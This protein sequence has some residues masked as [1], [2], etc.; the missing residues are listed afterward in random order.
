MLALGV[1]FFRVYSVSREFQKNRDILW[2]LTERGSAKPAAIRLIRCYDTSIF[3][4]I[5][6]QN[7]EINLKRKSKRT[8]RI[9][10]ATAELGIALFSRYKKTTVGFRLHQG[11]GQGGSLVFAWLQVGPPSAPGNGYIPLASVTPRPPHTSGAAKSRNGAFSSRG[12]MRPAIVFL[13]AGPIRIPLPKL[14]G[15]AKPG[16]RLVS[17]TRS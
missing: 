4:P 2:V 17:E 11:R 12:R 15:S 9:F 16:Q 8:K 14:D 5:V 7:K 6:K 10:P 3:G 13:S 1:S